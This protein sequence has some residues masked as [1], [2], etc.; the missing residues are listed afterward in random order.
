MRPQRF[1]FGYVMIH[2]SL[3]AK[4]EHNAHGTTPTSQKHD[5]NPMGGNIFHHN[6]HTSKINAFSQHLPEPNSWPSTYIRWR[7]CASMH[8]S[9]HINLLAQQA[10]GSHVQIHKDQSSK[11]TAQSLPDTANSCQL[12]SQGAFLIACCLP[13]TPQTLAP[14]LR[15]TSHDKEVHD[16]RDL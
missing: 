2:G 15:L 6:A 5:T 14:S 1:A 10:Q 8:G 16:T 7:K 3:Q 9:A 12:L 4:A 13:T 11:D